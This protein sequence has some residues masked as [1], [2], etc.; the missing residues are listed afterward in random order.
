M[1]RLCTYIAG[2]HARAARRTLAVVAKLKRAGCRILSARYLPS[3]AVQVDAPPPPAQIPLDIGYIEPPRGARPQPCE[4]VAT[5]RNVRIT[6]F[7]TR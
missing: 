6:W 5:L 3:P 1:L 4:H 7:A 2:P